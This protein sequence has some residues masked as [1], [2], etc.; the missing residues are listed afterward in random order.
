MPARLLI[1]GGVPLRG[2]VAASAAKNAALP[3]LAAALLTARAAWCSR[4]CPTLA[5]VRTMLALLETL[6]AHRRS[7][8][9]TAGTRITRAR[10]D[11]PRGALRPASRPCAPPC[12]VLGP[13]VARTAIGARGAARR[14]RHRRAPDRPAPQGAGAAGRGDRRSRTATWRRGPSRLK[15][16]RITT[17]LVT[18]TG[19]EN[20]M[21]AAALAEGTT[22]IENA[23]REPEVVGPRRACSRPWARSIQGAGTERDRDR[24]RGRAAAARAHR[25]HPRPHRGGHAAG[26][27]APSPAATS[28]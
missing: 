21:M 22:V 4:T 1:E 24:G 17:D 18:V 25:D 14:L 15:G 2:E 7:T 10:G 16:A 6:G 3:A 11:E 27:G 28:P 26:G 23:A 13:L 5:D 19:T 20:L 9:P 12:S 8:A